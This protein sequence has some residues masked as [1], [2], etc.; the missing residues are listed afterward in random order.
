MD[1]LDMAARCSDVE[2]SDRDQQWCLYE[3][4]RQECRRRAAEGEQVGCREVVVDS[5]WALWGRDHR[6]NKP[7]NPAITN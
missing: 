1:R 6:L 7:W 5:L 2:R 3:G 4:A